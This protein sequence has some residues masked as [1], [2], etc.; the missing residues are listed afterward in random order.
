MSFQVKKIDDLW[1]NL[2]VNKVSITW[3][4]IFF[5]ELTA[6]KSCEKTFV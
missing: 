1:F 2:L 5:Q 6:E 3:D 4:F